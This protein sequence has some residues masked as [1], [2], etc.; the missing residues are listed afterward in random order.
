MT[1]SSMAHKMG[2]KKKKGLRLSGSRIKKKAS[3]KCCSSS[4]KNLYTNVK[5]SEDF[6]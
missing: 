1:F 3:H 6:Q 2:L 5:L 4:L